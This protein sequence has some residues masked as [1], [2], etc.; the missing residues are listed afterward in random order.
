MLVHMDIL[1][2]GIF[3]GCANR[4]SKNSSQRGR[5]WGRNN[6]RNGDFGRARKQAKVGEGSETARRL[7][8]FSSGFVASIEQHQEVLLRLISHQGTGVHVSRNPYPFSHPL[9]LNEK[10]R[11][12]GNRDSHY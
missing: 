11:T 3:F 4:I 10:S 8:R 6:L 2:T 12:D 5:R 1:F 7:R 9:A